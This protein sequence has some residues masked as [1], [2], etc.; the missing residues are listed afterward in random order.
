MTSGLREPR[1]VGPGSRRLLP[2]A[3]GSAATG[4]H[5]I[6]RH[7]RVCRPVRGLARARGSPE[8]LPRTRRHPRVCRRLDIRPSRVVAAREVI[9][10]PAARPRT[11]PIRPNSVCAGLGVHGGNHRRPRLVALLL[12]HV[13]TWLPP[14][15]TLCHAPNQAGTL[16][17]TSRKYGG[18]LCLSYLVLRSSMRMSCTSTSGRCMGAHCF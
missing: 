10:L 11:A 1:P 4:A 12:P 17:S 16:P 15:P 13:T 5:A 2:C 18:S 6:R 3:R 8:L 14:S 9:R 7:A